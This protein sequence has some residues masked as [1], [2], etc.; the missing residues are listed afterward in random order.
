M[1][2]VNEKHIVRFQ[3][4]K[5]TGQITR[6]V[7]HR[8]G[9]NLEAYSQFVGYNVGKCG[10]SQSGRTMKQYMIQGLA[11]EAGS[12]YENTQ[13]INHFILSAEILEIQRT[14]SVLEVTLLAGQLMITYVKIFLFHSKSVYTATKIMQI[15]QR[16]INSFLSSSGNFS[17]A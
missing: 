3:T 11:S 12:L 17:M 13:I 1:Y 14:E 4:G 16:F 9:S 8:P 2:F 15:F 6:L 5:D 7:E 10:F